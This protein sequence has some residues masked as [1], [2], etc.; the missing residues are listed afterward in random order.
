M[1]CDGSIGNADKYI[2]KLCDKK[3]L[4][5]LGCYPI[6]MPGNYIAMFS[7]PTK[8][9]ALEIIYEAETDIEKTV[10]FIKDGMR[11][12]HPVLTLKDKMNSG[13]VNDI[14]YPVFVHARKFYAEDTCI[15]CGKCANVCPMNNIRI[16]NGKPV[17]GKAC[18]HCMSCISRC[19]KEAIEYGNH[20]KG[21]TRYTFPKQM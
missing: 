3:K 5:Y 20:S 12:S 16:E 19:P 14:F 10:H 2:N 11:F 6:I 8:E 7:A 9:K 21:K 1:T 17:W 18:T 15:S 4:N 13:I